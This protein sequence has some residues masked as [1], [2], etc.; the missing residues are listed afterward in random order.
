VSLPD[1][2]AGVAGPADWPRRRAELLEFFSAHV[3]GRT[4][5]SAGAVDVALDLRLPSDAAGPVPAF[6]GL[7]WEHDAWPWELVTSRGY[8][9]ASAVYT[10]VRPDADDGRPRADDECGALGQW[11][12]ALSLLLDRLVADPRVDAS[13]VAVIGHSRLGKVALWA[14]AQDS[15]FAMA[16]SNCSG[17]GGAALSRRDVGESVEAITTS[18]PHWFCP[19]FASYAGREDELPVDQHEL[20][21]LIAPRPVF[22]ASAAEDTWADPDGERLS[23]AAAAPVFRLLGAEPPAYHCREG[24]HELRVEDWERYLDAADRWL[25]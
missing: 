24:G 4:P 15:R 13:R 6:L 22:V 10:D 1:P 11:A 21:A 23:T 18:F 17:C 9:L 3:Y 12:R 5:P 8:A 2:L 25:A 20:L 16:V 19:A 7:R 14:A